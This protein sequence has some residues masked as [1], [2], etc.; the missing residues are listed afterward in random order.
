[1]I[2]SDSETCFYCKRK[3]ASRPLMEDEEGEGY[4]FI[5][6]ECAEKRDIW[7]DDD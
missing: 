2:K 5:C 4:H 6:H 7:F 3:V 1:M